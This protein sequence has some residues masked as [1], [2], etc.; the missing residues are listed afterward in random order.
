MNTH[1]TSLESLF[2]PLLSLHPNPDTHGQKKAL[3]ALFRI[4]ELT[5]LRWEG[6]LMSFYSP[7]DNNGSIGTQTF[8]NSTPFFCP[9][10]AYII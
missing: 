6:N 3:T 4:H 7:K 2:E 8:C 9:L 1:S 5:N 10:G